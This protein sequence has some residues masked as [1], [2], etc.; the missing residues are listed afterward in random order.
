MIR[1]P[2]G[3]YV[4]PDALTHMCQKHL[5]AVAAGKPFKCKIKNCSVKEGHDAIK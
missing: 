1:C 2:N 5:R 3:C 4:L